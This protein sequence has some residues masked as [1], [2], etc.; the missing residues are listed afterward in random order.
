VP[1]LVTGD[2]AL[3]ISIFVIKPYKWEGL[4]VFDDAY[5][6]PGQGAVRRRR[7]KM[8]DAA[9]AHIPNAEKG[10]LAVFSASYFPNAQIV[11]ECAREDGGSNVYHWKEKYMEGWLCPALL[12]C[13]M[14]TESFAL[15]WLGERKKCI[16]LALAGQ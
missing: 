3:N 12:R 7:G 2:R 9:T 10:F 8:I 4:W 11:V 6:G 5:V 14:R 13:F 16:K 1:A 15:G